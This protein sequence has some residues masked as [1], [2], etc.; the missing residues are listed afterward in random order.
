MKKIIT[1]RFFI[2]VFYGINFIWAQD[3]ILVDSIIPTLKGKI[4]HYEKTMVINGTPSEVFAF[5]D[6]IN[7]TGMHMMK[8]NT[9]MIG[10][11][12]NLEWLTSYTTG[13]GTKYKW[14]GKVMGMKMNFTVLVIDWENGRL[15]TWGTVGA[16]KMIVISWFK[17]K[18]II[19][20]YENKGSIVNLKIDYIKSNKLLGFIAGRVY[21]KWCVKSMLKDT[22]RHFKEHAKEI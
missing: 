22:N 16:A 17:M 21:S 6:D 2:I 5:M 19:T 18:L 9:Q 4:K 14:T 7:N 12:L 11:R 20:P 13:L 1:Y 10:S 15:K 3:S 8:S